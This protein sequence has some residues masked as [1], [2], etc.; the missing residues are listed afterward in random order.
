[1]ACGKPGRP[2]RRRARPLLRWEFTA[3]HVLEGPLA[4]DLL[5]PLPSYGRSDTSWG[6][7]VWRPRLRGWT[8]SFW[9]GLSLE[10]VALGF[11]PLSPKFMAF[12]TNVS[13]LVGL[14]VGCSALPTEG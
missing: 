13:S 12:D 4:L 6:N 7:L 10:R 2:Q 8:S 3:G 11:G 5:H 1:M 9:L 14:D